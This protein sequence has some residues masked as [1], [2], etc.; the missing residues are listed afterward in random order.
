MKTH[1]IQPEHE[2]PLF[3]TVNLARHRN[4][5]PREAVESPPVGILKAWQDTVL[6]NLV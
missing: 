3:C 4:T 5:L 2:T 1:K 6:G